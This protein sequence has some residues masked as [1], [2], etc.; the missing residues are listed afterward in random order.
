[1]YEW[2]SGCKETLLAAL[3]VE[4]ML[5]DF[6]GSLIGQVYIQR[7]HWLSDRSSAF[8]GSLSGQV[9]YRDFIGSLA[10]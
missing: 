9:M 5:R 10:G 3:K 6:I 7:P 8:I 2:S 1:M 4:G